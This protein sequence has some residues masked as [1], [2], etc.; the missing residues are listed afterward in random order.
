[1]PVIEDRL[2]VEARGQ[3][4]P[5]IL[6]RP[7]NAGARTPLVLAGHGGGFG[8]DG[9]KRVDEIVALAHHLAVEHGIATVAI[10]Q[11]GC[12]DRDGAAEEQARRRQMTVAEAVASLWTRELVEELIGYWGLS[13]GTTFGLPLVA[14]ERRIAAAVLGLNGNVPL[15][16]AYAAD[17]TCPVL[18]MMNLDDR[19]MSRASCLALFDRLGSVDKHVVAYPGDHGENLHRS[20]EE[21]GRFF[22]DRLGG[23]DRGPTA[24]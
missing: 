18:Y 23:R 3:A 15:M 5:G 10:D 17:V 12:G 14:T 19:F 2:A 6:W 11:P 9:H 4:V 20:R 1:M 13:G 22:A 8:T 7:S 21:W 24:R 16:Q